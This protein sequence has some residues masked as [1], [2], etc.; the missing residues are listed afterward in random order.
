MVV[1]C[2]NFN[3]SP[4]GGLA[5]N[6]PQKANTLLSNVGIQDVKQAVVNGN[7]LYCAIK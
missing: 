1:Y 2:A 4:V 6:E 3:G 7:S 5:R